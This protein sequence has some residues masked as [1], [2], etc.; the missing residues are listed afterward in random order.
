MYCRQVGRVDCRLG[1][2][3]AECTV[4]T[5]VALLLLYSVHIANEIVRIKLTLM[6]LIQIC[7]RDSKSTKIQ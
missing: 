2:F 4:L 1:W 5:T 7:F 6:T 3:Y